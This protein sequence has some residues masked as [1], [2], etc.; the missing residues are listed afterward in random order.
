VRA[1]IKNRKISL[2]SLKVWILPFYSV[3]ARSHR[4]IDQL[5]GRGLR[6]RGGLD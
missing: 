4:W 6:L 3:R 2:I 1:R 5:P